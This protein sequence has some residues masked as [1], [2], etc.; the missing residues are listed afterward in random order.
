MKIAITG[1]TKGIGKALYDHFQTNGHEVLGFSRSNGFELPRDYMTVIAEAKE[2]DVFVNN[3]Y[4]GNAQALILTQICQFD[5]ANQEKHII[6]IGSISSLTPIHLQPMYAANKAGLK[7]VVGN[8]QSKQ[9]LPRITN[10]NPGLVDT[11]GSAAIKGLHRMAVDDIVAIV[12]FCLKFPHTVLDISFRH[13][14]DKYSV[15]Y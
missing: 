5:W 6:N 8:F 3:A 4:A 9:A 11:P 2:C 12:D 7:R 1:H 13:K 15:T 14:D 10:L